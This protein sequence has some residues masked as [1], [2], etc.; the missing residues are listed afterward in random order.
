MKDKFT[1]DD[2]V[3]VSENSSN[4]VINST[5]KGDD[6]A[7]YVVSASI[8]KKERPQDSK[9]IHFRASLRDDNDH[10]AKRERY[11]ANKVAKNLDID[12]PANWKSIPVSPRK[13][14]KEEEE[15]IWKDDEEDQKLTSL[16]DSWKKLIKKSPAKPED[17]RE[18][19]S[20]FEGEAKENEEAKVATKR[21]Q[22]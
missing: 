15:E 7:T 1:F 16:I 14:V 21:R 17:S 2:D 4:Q 8:P 9:R 12:D 20:M 3:N 22:N 5:S 6:G 10:F 19:D 11:L 13:P 18:L